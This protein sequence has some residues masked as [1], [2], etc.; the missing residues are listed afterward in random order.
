ML[1]FGY[2]IFVYYHIIFKN[3]KD[4]TECDFK[5]AVKRMNFQKTA[6]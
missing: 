1:L 4:V 2:F 5:Y 3:K 6:K